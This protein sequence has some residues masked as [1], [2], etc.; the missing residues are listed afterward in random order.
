MSWVDDGKEMYHR[1]YQNPWTEIRIVLLGPAFSVKYYT[2]GW[3]LL[4]SYLRVSM[5]I[6][7][8]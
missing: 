3:S 5:Y 6:K 1:R 2:R 4:N 7:T 8:G